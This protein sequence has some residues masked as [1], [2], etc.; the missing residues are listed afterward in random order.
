MK[1]LK[2]FEYNKKTK[3]SVGDYVFI[4]PDDTVDKYAKITGIE[5][6]KNKH[7]KISYDIDV[8]SSSDDLINTFIFPNEIERK[9]TPDE[10]SQYELRIASG[11]YNL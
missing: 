11:K 6:A 7:S 10:I 1:Y 4:N 8:F 2:K 9:M 5:K 3:Y